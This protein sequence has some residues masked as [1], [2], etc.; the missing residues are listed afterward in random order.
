MPLLRAHTAQVGGVA[1]YKAK[2][3][4]ETG[5]GGSSQLISEQLPGLPG[6]APLV[7]GV[8]VGGGRTRQECV[9]QLDARFKI[10]AAL[11]M[12]VL[13]GY[14]DRQGRNGGSRFEPCSSER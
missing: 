1:V 3:D 2:R 12:P 6:E 11:F 7:T 10:L 8:G 5:L 14:F 13:L 4:G 9:R